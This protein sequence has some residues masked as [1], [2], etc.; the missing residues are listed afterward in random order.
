MTEEILKI[1]SIGKVDSKTF[2]KMIYSIFKLILFNKGNELVSFEP[3][4]NIA[5]KKVE[6]LNLLTGKIDIDALGKRSIL[7]IRHYLIILFAKLE[8]D[9]INIDVIHQLALTNKGSELK[10]IVEQKPSIYIP[11]DLQYDNK[12]ESH[13]GE[14][15]D[16]YYQ[17]LQKDIE[18]AE[19]EIA[20]KGSSKN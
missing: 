17:S 12:F 2:D 5:K 11:N 19:K 9:E 13:L 8:N 18:E 4:I 3:K 7:Q 14:Y 10:K 16:E 6:L 20:L 15:N 1:W